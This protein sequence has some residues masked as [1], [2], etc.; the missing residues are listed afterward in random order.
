MSKYLEYY[1]FHEKDEDGNEIENK[2]GYFKSSII[3]NI[4]KIL[5]E[6][7][8]NLIHLTKYNKPLY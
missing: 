2:Y 3:S 8:H 5:K 6:R 4:N 1:Q 7:H